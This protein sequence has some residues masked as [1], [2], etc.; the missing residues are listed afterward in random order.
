VRAHQIEHGSFVMDPRSLGENEL[1]IVAERLRSV[2]GEV[3]RTRHETKADTVQ[4][5][6][7]QRANALRHWPDAQTA[8]AP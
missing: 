8:A 2:I 6:K 3:R 7:A 5:W 4:A 1:G